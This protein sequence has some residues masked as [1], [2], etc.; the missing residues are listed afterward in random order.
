MDFNQ[1]E[2]KFRD[3]KVRFAAGELT[4]ADLKAHL[5]DLMV[6]DEGGN[7]WTLGY[8]TE[9]WYR[10]DGTNWVLADPP[11]SRAQEPAKVQPTKTE[12]ASP[13]TPRTV[14]S[15]AAL[16][17]SPV[18]FA[19]AALIVVAVGGYF[20]FR[21]SAA[22]TTPPTPTSAPVLPVAVKPADT[23]T[24]SPT[25]EPSPTPAPGIEFVASA[26]ASQVILYKGP[27]LKYGQV[28]SYPKGQQF[29]V[30]ARNDNGQ[31]LLVSADGVEGWVYFQWV[32]ADFDFSLL[33][34][35]SVMPPPIPTAT[36]KPKES[37][38]KP[39]PCSFGC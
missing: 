16:R 4:E 29:A 20:V 17:R 33:P 30:L 22:K 14:Q 34:T 24:P 21:P 18:V 23:A 37:N 38:N 13:A 12:A 28:K 36:R 2:E 25:A 8:E 15:T 32:E 9:R 11:E 10:Y 27:D 31:W 7:W 5:E 26:A 19:A 1:A 39:T 3:L 35:P 6:E